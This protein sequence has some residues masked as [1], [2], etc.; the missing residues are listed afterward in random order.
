MYRKVN[1]T[2]LALAAAVLGAA[3]APAQQPPAPPNPGVNSAVAPGGGAHQHLDTRFAHNHYYYDR[4]Y[5]VHSPPAGGLTTNGPDGQRYCFHDGN[6]YRFSDQ[7]RNM[8][9]LRHLDEWRHLNQWWHGEWVISAPPVGLFVPALPPYYT[10]IW[11][12]GTAYYYANGTYYVWDNSRNAYQIIA[13]PPGLDSAGMTPAPVIPGA[14]D[15]LFAYPTRS[16]TPEQQSDERRECHQW[17]NAETSYDPTAPDA[18]TQPREK[19]NAYFRAQAACLEA[20]GY[21]VR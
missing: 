4:G 2:V 19:R 16:Q 7:W 8:G 6:W 10:T 21:T 11:W 9:E 5:A 1:C 17:A 15:Q 13:P 14:T 12:T 3:S 18:A 20:R